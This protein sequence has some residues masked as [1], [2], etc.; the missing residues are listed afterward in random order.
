MG[1]IGWISK[2]R[3]SRRRRR[4]SKENLSRKSKSKHERKSERKSSPGGSA[5]TPSLAKPEMRKESGRRRARSLDDKR[6]E[7]G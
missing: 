5:F 3:V 7:S 1:R 6:N 2:R 4:A